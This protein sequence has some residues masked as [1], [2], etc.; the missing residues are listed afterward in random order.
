M[1][2]NRFAFLIPFLEFDD[3]E[4]RRQTM[5]GR[6]ICHNSWIFHENQQKTTKGAANPLPYFDVDETLH[7]Y[8]G[9]IGM[10]QYNPSKPAKYGLLYQNLCDAKVLYTYSHP[11]I[12]PKKPEVIGAND[13]YA[14]NCDEI[15]QN[16]WWTTFK[17]IELCKGETFL[18]IDTSPA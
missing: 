10:K 17:F 4:T 14:T 13:Y 15:Y 7:P 12:C 18:S 9:R 8:R 3:K 11:T 2:Y 6:Q 1:N 5:E 16:S